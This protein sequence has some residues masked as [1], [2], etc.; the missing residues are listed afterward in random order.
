MSHTAAIDQQ[1][2]LWATQR[3]QRIELNDDLTASRSVEHF[4]CFRRRAAAHTAASALQAAG[5]QVAIDRRGLKTV[6][7]ATRDE[8][9]DDETVAGFITVV[10]TIV[11]DAKGE[12]DGWGAMVERP[13]VPTT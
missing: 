11:E 7:Q 1:I 9:L 6:V 8:T 12:Y 5:F 10:V 2:A 3:E 4:A 13:G